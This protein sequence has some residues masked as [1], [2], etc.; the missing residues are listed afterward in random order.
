VDPFTKMAHLI[1]L[2]VDRKRT[3]D[4]IRIFAREYWRLHGIP[5]DI[6]SD[7]DSRFTS[8][9]WQDFLDHVGVKSRM[10]TAFH[11]QTDGQTERV[12]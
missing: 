6:I 1:P 3:D 8:G 10:S 12:N 9:L 4:L 2:K 7:R 11:P 5:M